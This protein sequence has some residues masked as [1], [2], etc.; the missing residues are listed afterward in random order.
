[1]TKRRTTS[2]EI[3]RIKPDVLADLAEDYRETANPV[4]PWLAMLH[5]QR[6]GKT[7]PEWAS[8]YFSNAAEGIEGLVQEVSDGGRP[9][10]VSERI[11]QRLGFG[12]TRE[13]GRKWLKHTAI[14]ERDWRLHDAVVRAIV[15]DEMKRDFAYVKVAKAHG[16]SVAT[17]ARAFIRM[18]GDI[19]DDEEHL[20]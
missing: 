13:G 4:C 5:V 1:M 9:G 20:S 7:L 6:S 17:V 19:Q 11:A 16:V 18:E 10:R 14:R 2:I 8:K 15:Y 3:M 12:G